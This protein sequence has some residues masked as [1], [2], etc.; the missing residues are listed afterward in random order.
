MIAILEE[1]FDWDKYVNSLDEEGQEKVQ[2]MRDD[3]LE[4]VLSWRR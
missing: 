4:E 1:F 2:Q 3:Y